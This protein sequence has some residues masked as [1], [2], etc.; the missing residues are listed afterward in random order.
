MTPRSLEYAIMLAHGSDL[1]DEEVRSF[2]VQSTKS[3]AFSTSSYK[4]LGNKMQRKPSDKLKP[5]N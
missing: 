2:S 4:M 5:Q 3:R 1:A